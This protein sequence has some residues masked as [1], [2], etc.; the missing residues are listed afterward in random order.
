[1]NPTRLDMMRYRFFW[2][3]AVAD[4]DKRKTKKSE[5]V[6]EEPKEQFLQYDYEWRGSL[7][8]HNSHGDKVKKVGGNR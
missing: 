8:D 1:M 4:F 5:S 2:K 7:N 3:M 6:A